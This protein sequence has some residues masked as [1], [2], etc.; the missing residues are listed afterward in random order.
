L[1]LEHL[2][3]LAWVSSNVPITVSAVS[4]WRTALQREACFPASVL[5]PVLLRELRRLAS[6]CFTEVIGGQRQKLASFCRRAA[7]RG[8]YRSAARFASTTLFLEK[9]FIEFYA[10]RK[11]K[12]FLKRE[13]RVIFV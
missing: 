4:P 6:N 9:F 10:Y 12:L 11:K 13:N 3:Q 7:D 1:R 5:G 2:A 8:E